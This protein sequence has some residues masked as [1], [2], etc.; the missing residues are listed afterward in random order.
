MR[1]MVIIKITKI[2]IKMRNK[3]IMI[4][5]KKKKRKKKQMENQKNTYCSKVY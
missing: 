2:I 4:N 1:I 5:Q 3:M